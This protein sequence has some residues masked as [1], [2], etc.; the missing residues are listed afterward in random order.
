ML[1]K[2]FNPRVHSGWFLGF[3]VVLIAVL[4]AGTVAIRADEQN[5]FRW[6]IVGTGQ[7]LAADNSKILLGG[8][9]TF[10]LEDPEEVTTNNGS[11]ET[12][13]SAGNVTGSGTFQVTSLVKFDL[14]PGAVGD[15]SIHAGLAFLRITY[16]DGSRGIL[17]VSCHLP[18]TPS[19]VAEGIS[20]SKGFTN[21]WKGFSTPSFFQTVTESKN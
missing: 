17:V 11:W 19:S 21:Y 20:A 4:V 1:L 5:T 14:A 3:A 15:P 8:S 6:V 10:V 12:L 9:G 18:G 16:S 7:A 13:G 2:T